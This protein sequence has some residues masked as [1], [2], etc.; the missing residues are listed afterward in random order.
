MGIIRDEA[1]ETRYKRTPSVEA[2]G[3]YGV[4]A[5]TPPFTSDIVGTL[6]LGLDLPGSDF[7]VLCLAPDARVFADAVWRTFA[8]RSRLMVEQ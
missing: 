4:L 3:V 8:S 5:A 6:Q 7:D 2:F 1:F